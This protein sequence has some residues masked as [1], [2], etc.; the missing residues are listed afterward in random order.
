[1]SKKKLL[2]PKVLAEGRAG[3]ILLLLATVGPLGQLAVV[4]SGSSSGET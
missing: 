4:P 1:M 2:L 3:G